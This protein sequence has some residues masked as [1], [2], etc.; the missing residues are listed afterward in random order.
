M[1]SERNTNQLG[2][3]NMTPY[4][5]SLLQGRIYNRRKK[6]QGG[7]SDRSVG[8]D[9]MSIPNTAERLADQ[10]G[11]TER[12]IRRDGQFA[13]AVETLKPVIP[14]IERRVMS[15]DVPSKHRQLDGRDILGI[16]LSIYMSPKTPTA[17]RID[18][19]LLEAMRTYKDREGVPLTTQIEKAVT[20]WLKVRGI[21]VK[22]E[23]KRAATRKRS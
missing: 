11:V 1:A 3:R 12:T 21:Q 14:D 4:Q 20:E 8:A 6:A 15:G 10:H 9:K 2:R 18:D 16:G 5:T 17:L 19:A 7:R 22:T 13:S 23:R